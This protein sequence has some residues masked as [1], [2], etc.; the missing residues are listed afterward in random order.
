MKAQKVLNASGLTRA[1]IARDSGL[2]EAT[3]WGWLNGRSVPTPESLEKLAEGLEKRGGE[4]QALAEEL[5]NAARPE[6]TRGT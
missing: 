5:R 3:I 6:R 2:N 1:Q 4:L